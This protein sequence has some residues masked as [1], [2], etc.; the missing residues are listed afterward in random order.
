[1]LHG[2]ESDPLVEQAPFLRPS[3]FRDVHSPPESVQRCAALH[4][5]ITRELTMKVVISG[6]EDSAKC[7]WC[8][9]DRECV[10]TTFSDGLFQNASLCWKCLQT[11]FRVRAAQAKPTAEEKPA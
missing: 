7:V 5:R 3:Q 4:L 11:A 8:E 10:K 2:N 6:R 9:K 1:M